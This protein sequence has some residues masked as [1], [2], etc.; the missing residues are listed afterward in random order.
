MITSLELAAL[1]FNASFRSDCKM[2]EQLHNR[3]LYKIYMLELVSASG[4][5]QRRRYLYLR[6]SSCVVNAAWAAP[7]TTSAHLSHHLQTTAVIRTLPPQMSAAVS[8]VLGGTR[9]QKSN[10]TVY[11]PARSF[12]VRQVVVSDPDSRNTNCWDKFHMFNWPLLKSNYQMKSSWIIFTYYFISRT[13]FGSETRHFSHNL[14]WNSL[15]VSVQF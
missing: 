13:L 7:R 6:L 11:Q 12:Q 8:D 2:L 9:L 5:D 1:P 3:L 15:W 4:V 10:F 14:S